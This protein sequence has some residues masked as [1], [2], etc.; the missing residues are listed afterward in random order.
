[1]NSVYQ[2]ETAE[3]SEAELDNVAGGLAVH[4]GGGLGAGLAVGAA[5]TGEACLQAESCVEIAL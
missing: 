5:G 4:A 1:M 3:I 2:V